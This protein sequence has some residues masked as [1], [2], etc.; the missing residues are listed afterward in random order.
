[1]K[2][3]DIRNRIK[4]DIKLNLLPVT[5]VSMKTVNDIISHYSTIFPK[6]TL[7]HVVPSII[8]EISRK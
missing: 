7:Q 8:Q 4:Q 6:R 1:M 2:V 5:E 3:V